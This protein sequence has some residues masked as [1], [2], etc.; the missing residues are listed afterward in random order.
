MAEK[1]TVAEL[2]INTDAFLKAATN[3]KGVLDGLRTS[4][5]ALKKSGEQ[6]T[7]QFVKNEVAIKRL[8]SQ[9]TEQKNVLVSLNTQN[10]DFAK[11][12]KAIN[13]AVSKENTTIQQ[14]RNNNKELLKVRNQLNTQTTA[15]KA[16]LKDINGKLDK[17][18]KLIKENV[19]GYEKQKIN[20]GNY[21]G[22]LRS[23]FP[24]MNGV[25][26][27][28]KQTKIAL[29][30]HKASTI[31]SA[32]ATGLFSGALKIFKIALISTGVGAI[33]VAFGSLIA[34]LSQ[35][36]KGM[37]AVSR[38]MKAVGAAVDVL[39]DRFIAVG[40]IMTKIFSQSIFKTL[41][42]VKESFSGIGDEIQRDIDLA[43][44]LER[45]TQKLRDAEIDEIVTQAR[46][47]KMIQENRLLAKDQ[48]KTLEQR[49]GFLDLAIA[50]EKANLDEQVAFAKER[51]RIAQDEYDRATSD[52]KDLE[53]LNQLKAATIELETSSLKK[54][55]TF[56]SERQG[57]LKKG[58]AEDVKA[59][60]AKK[61]EVEAELQAATE[62]TEKELAR[63]TDFE[64]RKRDLKNEIALANAA[65]DEE[66]ELLKIE[67]DTEKQLLELEKLQLDEEQKT[68][69][70][71]LMETNRQ[72]IIDEIITTAAEERYQKTLEI[73]K[74]EID[75]STKL[76]ESD[77]T[78]AQAR[79]NVATTLTGIL[80][81]LLGDSLGAK[82]ASIAIEA[83]IQAGLVKIQGS[84]ASGK[85]TAGITAANA[86][87]I[88][89]SPL[90]AGLP[91]TAIN[92]AQGVSLQAANAASVTKSIAGILTGAALKS[93]GTIATKAFY[94]GG[95]ITGQ[96]IPTQAGGDNIL[97]TVKSGEVILNE[98]QQ[99]RAGGAN[100]FKS[101]G[102]PGFNTGGVAMSSNITAPIQQGTSNIDAMVDAI[103]TKI[104]DIKVVAI[105]DEI[106]GQQ[107]LKAEIVD[108]ATI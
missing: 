45:A 92:T 48:T 55:L 107:Q 19:S 83:G 57:L 72:Q 56:E 103:A 61:K 7:E 2:D 11:T 104:N 32:G 17:N 77:K 38:V 87:A 80:N 100:F 97:A 51:E 78:N 66:R 40:E 15:G 14:A 52:A 96:N 42:D 35:T 37:D 63:I 16:A 39:V 13:D 8:S 25:L 18:N 27:T 54:Q 44:E 3:T 65:T 24:Q 91:F 88:A 62:A 73:N 60:E 64:N 82:L 31:A 70:L 28:L 93:A 26:N 43:I 84:A 29:D 12:T 86:A 21:E 53:G 41:G 95:L 69:L 23:V 68:E 85:I 20:I 76:T 58:R 71:A 47:R 46:R 108:A 33:V 49:I 98:E 10:T 50:L 106:T 105:V 99:A 30:L 90:T 5:Q 81:G 75:A 74:K 36:Q 102:V 67:Q 79:A 1:I 22:A 9:Y 34:Y 6:G 101:I 94:S 89:A 4:Q 59:S